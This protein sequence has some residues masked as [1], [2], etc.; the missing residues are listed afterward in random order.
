MPTY[1]SDAA[2]FEAQ[3]PMFSSRSKFSFGDS[4]DLGPSQRS[5]VQARRLVAVDECKFCSA[6]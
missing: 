6:K 1:P 3:L 4:F 2:G 5:S